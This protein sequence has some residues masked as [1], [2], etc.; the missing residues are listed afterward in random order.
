MNSIQ[1]YLF[2]IVCAAA[3][4][5]LVLS[6]PLQKQLKRLL[7]LVCGCVMVLLTLTPLCALDIQTLMHTLP[8]LIENDISVPDGQNDALLQAL[9]CEQT[10]Q[11]I[12]DKAK[13]LGLT[14]QAE[15]TVRYDETVGSYL[16]YGVT[17]TV[18]GEGSKD[19]LKRF[20]TEELAIAEARQIWILN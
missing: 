13:A 6:L 20:V 14:A 7:G 5:S 11:V 4:S 17:V 15:V 8:P 9:I 1:A 2:R 19:A 18:S 10:E 3:L 16:P 12:A